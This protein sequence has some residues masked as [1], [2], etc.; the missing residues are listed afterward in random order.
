[1][2]GVDGARAA[3]SAL[4]WRRSTFCASGECVEVAA[5]NGMILIRD[6]KLP[7][8]ILRVSVGDFQA[9]AR[10]VRAGQFDDIC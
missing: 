7:E 3:D 8:M 9:F 1:M 6:S 4:G 5:E 2:S 10:G